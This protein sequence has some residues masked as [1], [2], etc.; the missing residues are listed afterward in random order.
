MIREIIQ[1]LF[2]HDLGR[3]QATG[4]MVLGSNSQFCVDIHSATVLRNCEFSI[5]NNDYANQSFAPT[6]LKMPI[7]NHKRKPPEQV[8]S[9]THL[10]IT[11]PVSILTRCRWSIDKHEFMRLS[12]REAIMARSI[13]LKPAL[14]R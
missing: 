3:L 5:V 14:T 8:S 10:S 13:S 2:I 1:D 7:S 6:E 12:K 4:L 11:V 9:L